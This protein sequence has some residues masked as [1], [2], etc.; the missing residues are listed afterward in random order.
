MEFWYKIE[1][2][3]GRKNSFFKSR[4]IKVTKNKKEVEKAHKRIF[5]LEKIGY[6][7]ETWIDKK[8]LR[9]ILPNVSTDCLGGILVD[10]DGWAKPHEV[11]E[12]FAKKATYHGATIL[13]NTSVKCFNK[14]HNKWEVVTTTGRF[15]TNKIINCAGAWG[16]KIAEKLGD[17]FPIK[18]YAPMLAMTKPYPITLK[19][20]VGILG[21][22]LSLKQI[23]SG[24]FLIGGGARAK[25]SLI[26]NKSNLRFSG[27]KEMLNNA[28]S[29]FPYLNDA[30][31]ERSWSGIEGY[32]PDEMPVIG[33]G[34]DKSVIH[35][36]GFS[37]HG[38]Q[39]GPAVG[40][41]LADLAM[42]RQIKVN[43]SAFSPKRFEI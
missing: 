33:C 9:N 16:G 8:E 4:Y 7:H 11:V 39:L 36:F 34:S 20:I 37:A 25:A 41:A 2:L 32:M 19:A 12:G 22:K 18:A 5:E 15:Y 13:E 21:L 3:I 43:L 6:N 10:G 17:F 1:E 30:I 24:Q 28:I 14:K 42:N 31:I 27:I 40:E 38:F 26:K 29:V 23:E 35:C